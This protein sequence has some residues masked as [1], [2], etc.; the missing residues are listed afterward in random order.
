MG[1][2]IKAKAVCPV[3]GKALDEKA[4][5]IGGEWI[6]DECYK[7]YLKFKASQEV[8]ETILK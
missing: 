7:N 5:K 6:C 1:S 3:C 2:I 8:E 4:Q